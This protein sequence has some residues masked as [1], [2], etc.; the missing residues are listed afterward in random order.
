MCL[1]VDLLLQNCIIGSPRCRDLPDEKVWPRESDCE[2]RVHRLVCIGQGK[3]RCPICARLVC[4]SISWPTCII[5][6]FGP[7]DS[8]SSGG[9]GGSRGYRVACTMPQLCRL[10]RIFALCCICCV[11]TREYKRYT[12]GAIPIAVRFNKPIR[13][14]L[15]SF[16]G[17][18]FA[19]DFR[20]VI[21]G[22]CHSHSPLMAHHN[23]IIPFSCRLD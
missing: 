6:V 16:L 17:F 21:V 19:K 9:T 1:S 7:F 5:R 4:C 11:L 14:L 13:I 22:C 15:R 10:P 20:K 8:S 3:L 18:S 12:G 2:D 23:I